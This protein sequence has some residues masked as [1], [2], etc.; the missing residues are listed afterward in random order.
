MSTTQTT[1]TWTIT[2]DHTGAH[3]HCPACGVV[4]SIVEVDQAIRWNTIHLTD[5]QSG[6]ASTGNVGDYEFEG[7]ACSACGADNLDAPVGFEITD[8]Y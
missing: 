3:T 2:Q 4:D 8:W 1:L 6:T 5:A 7:W